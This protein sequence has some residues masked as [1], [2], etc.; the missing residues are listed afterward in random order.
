MSRLPQPGE[1]ARILASEVMDRIGAAGRC[2]EVLDHPG[3]CVV[4]RLDDGS[5]IE[6]GKTNVGED[7]VVFCTISEVELAKGRGDG[8]GE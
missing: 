6:W 4:V 7:G 8:R 3:I 5:G 2:G 1:R